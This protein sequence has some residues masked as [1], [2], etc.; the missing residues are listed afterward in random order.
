MNHATSN[1]AS[2]K[3]VAPTS[4]FH[5]RLFGFV[6]PVYAKL[7][8]PIVLGTLSGGGFD[9]ELKDILALHRPKGNEVMMDLGCGPGNFTNAFAK[10][11]PKGFM[12]GL[13]LAYPMLQVARSN[14]AKDNAPNTGFAQ[15]NAQVLPIKRN[16]IDFVS[17]CG[18]LHL[19]PQPELAL[20]EVAAILR[21]GGSLVGM[22]F[23]K[24]EWWGQRLIE[25]FF[26]RFLHFRF[27]PYDQVQ[28]MFADAG[29]KMEGCT[30]ARLILLFHAKKPG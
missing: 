19:L 9:K 25:R 21:P 26:N 27:F 22:T 28:K 2:S 13:D 7:W 1:A 15:C 18:A 29:L 17:F 3:D 4:G 16:S 14:A 24:G 8:K 11:A 20:A 10:L 5:G 23:V 12:A 30:R 6:A